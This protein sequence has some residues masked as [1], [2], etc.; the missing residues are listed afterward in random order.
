MYIHVYIFICLWGPRVRIPPPENMPI[1][2]IT[3]IRWFLSNAFSPLELSRIYCKPLKFNWCLLSIHWI[4]LQFYCNS[5]KNIGRSLSIN[6]CPVKTIGNHSSPFKS[7][8]M[9]RKPIGAHWN[10][11]QF[12][13]DLWIN[14]ANLFKGIARLWKVIKHQWNII[15]HL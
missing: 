13:A 8:E 9:I 6:W 7:I 5:F 3:L 11:L 14:I 15:G 2:E 1:K 10:S 4:L 12:T